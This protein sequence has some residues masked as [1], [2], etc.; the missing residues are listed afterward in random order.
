MRPV[1]RMTLLS[2][3]ALAITG[4]ATSFEP[5]PVDTPAALGDLQ[6]KSVGNV[7]VAVGDPHRRSRPPSTSA[8]ISRRTNCRRCG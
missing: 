8:W 1:A 7:T 2:L 3:L 6:S 5:R 4:C